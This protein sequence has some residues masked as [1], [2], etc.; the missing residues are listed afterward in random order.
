MS[1][2]GKLLLGQFGIERHL[3]D[4][5]QLG[6]AAIFEHD[7][8]L[9]HPWFDYSWTHQFFLRRLQPPSAPVLALRAASPTDTGPAALVSPLLPRPASAHAICWSHAASGP[10]QILL[11]GLAHL[12]HGDLIGWEQLWTS[13]AAQ[14][15]V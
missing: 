8:A 10:H 9:W 11:P 15:R 7:K 14:H 1:S 12:D 5:M 13:L 6:T 4:A 2:K 3:K